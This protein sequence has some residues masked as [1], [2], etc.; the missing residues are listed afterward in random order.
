MAES[1]PI[2]QSWL[3]T[4]FYKLTMGQFV[5]INYP[6]VSVRYAF[7]NRTPGVSLAKYIKEEDLRRE[8]DHVR[9]MKFNR[10][11]IKY[12][13][14]TTEYGKEMFQD[15]FIY[16]LERLELPPYNLRYE[17]DNFRLEFVGPWRTAIYWEIF[18]LAIVNELYYRSQSVNCSRFE[19]DLVYARGRLR[20][21]E[22]IKVLKENPDITFTD[23]GTRRRFS[24]D[25]QDYVVKTLG[26]E[27]LETRFRGT[28]NVWLAMKHG[29]MPMGTSA[30]ELFMVAAGM[31]DGG[32]EQVRC[33]QNEVLKRWWEMYGPGLSIA[34]SDTFGSDF[35]FRAMSPKQA[36]DWKGLRQ[37][38]GDPIEF[39]E[40]AI[41]F[42]ERC[43]VDPREKMIVFSDGLDVEA[44]V[45][46]H[47]HFAGRIKT[48]FGW[49][50]NLT[51]DMGFKPLSLVIKTVEA[52]GRG[53]VKL[54]DNLAKA[55][56]KPEDIERYKRIFGY[57]DNNFQECKY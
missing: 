4:D 21:A 44:I 52:E 16:F 18:A 32:D 8:L 28:S 37:D 42:Y 54:S 51:N 15:T 20:L 47:R 23:F 57:T 53:L 6:Q 40:K 26:G 13:R 31:T 56:G 2:I 39:G 10:S 38:S 29:L 36:V 45:K 9:K 11:E 33:S 43:K 19:H 24:R 22:K 27:F 3:D 50:T 12:L 49:G 34:L 55:I 17:E 30:H 5:L 41:K 7:K 14:G 48:T 1:E 25:W 35:F 46:I